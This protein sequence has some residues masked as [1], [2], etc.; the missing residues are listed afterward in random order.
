MET[1]SRREAVRRLTTA[2]KSSRGAGGYS[3]WVNRPAGRQLAALA[4]VLRL[5]PN[6]VSA[7]SAFCSYAGI[8]LIATQRPSWA[9]AVVI[10]A[11]LVL[12]YALDS[13]DGQLARLRGG[14]S[15][16]GEWLDHVLDAIKIVTIHLAV[17]ICWFR[18]F[19][20]SHPALLLI[21]L[22]FCAVSVVFF[23]AL[24]L[25]DLLRRVRRVEAGRSGVT[26]ASLDPHEA[27]PVLRSVVVLPNDYG[28]LC[29]VFLTLSVHTLF[30]VIYAVLL[31]AN[32]VFLVAGCARWFR[33]MSRL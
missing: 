17:A 33:E 23:F 21:P 1:L 12:G 29:L 28:V 5:T 19:R 13:A 16:A 27:A 11:L 25:A 7:V 8:I 4:Y 22:G 24:V 9:W 20:L 14:G 2:R 31:A 3:R 10:T 32:A 15:N 30:G 18:F 6:Q 26:T